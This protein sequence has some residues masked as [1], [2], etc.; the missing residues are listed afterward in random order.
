M[1]LIT[2]AV[3]YSNLFHLNHTNES[4]RFDTFQEHYAS[5]PGNLKAC[6]AEAGESITDLTA[7]QLIR[8]K[9]GHLKRIKEITD[10]WALQHRCFLRKMP[11]V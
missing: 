1:T 11:S 9:Q 8:H 6:P 3:L 10:W 7:S 5:K 2:Y 4:E